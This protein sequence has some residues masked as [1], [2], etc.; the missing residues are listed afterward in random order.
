M[1]EIIEVN[2]NYDSMW[3]GFLC[4]LDIRQNI[5]NLTDFVIRQQF[6][7]IDKQG[8]IFRGD[9]FDV[10][11]ASNKLIKLMYIL[12]PLTLILV[13]IFDL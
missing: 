9:G 2:Q 5:L 13:N 1:R 12:K 3:D 8:F 7:M 10:N 4:T 11:I 6:L